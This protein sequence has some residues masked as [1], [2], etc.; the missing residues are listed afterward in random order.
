MA[1]Y[2][3]LKSALYRMSGNM[4]SVTGKYGVGAVFQNKSNPVC[5]IVTFGQALRMTAGA[6]K[7]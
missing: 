1:L 4:H 3:V 2:Q 7:Q 6:Y 5:I